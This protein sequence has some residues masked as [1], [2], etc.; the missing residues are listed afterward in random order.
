MSEDPVLAEVAR[1]YRASLPKRASRQTVPRSDELSHALQRS[2]ISEMTA[3]VPT[4]IVAMNVALEF[5][6]DEIA[7]EYFASVV[8]QIRAA[9]P[10]VKELRAATKEE[11]RE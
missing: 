1:A 8:A 6:A 11:Q 9:A 5:G 7:Y 4:D 3:R 2:A 10:V